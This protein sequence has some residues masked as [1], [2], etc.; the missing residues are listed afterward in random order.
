MEKIIDL[1]MH[2]Y[3]D[4]FIRE[5][6]LHKPEPVYPLQ[7]FLDSKTGHVK[8]GCLTNSNERYNLYDYSY[9]SSNSEFSKKHWE[10]YALQVSEKLKLDKPI[11][12]LEIGSND[13]YL[14]YQFQREGHNVL[15]VDSSNYMAEIA[16]KLG[17]ETYCG[18]FDFNL[19]EVIKEQ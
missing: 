18:V 4:T 10:S 3:A 13:G 17:V 15:G 11:N 5:D 2:P 12:I 19:S 8:V 16:N 9:T 1:G 14:S 7:C 6:Q